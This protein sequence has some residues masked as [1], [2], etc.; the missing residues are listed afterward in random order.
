M[1]SQILSS[2]EHKG[3][4]LRL[5]TVGLACVSLL[6]GAEKGVCHNP[7]IYFKKKGNL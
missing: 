6:V 7:D 5:Q 2:M 3:P 1:Y 4:L